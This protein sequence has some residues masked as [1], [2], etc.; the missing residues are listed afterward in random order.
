MPDTRSKPVAAA[1]CAPVEGMTAPADL[2][3][4]LLVEDEDFDARRL[5]ATLRVALGRAIDVRRVCSVQEVSGAIAQSMPDI[6]FIDDYLGPS[7]SALQTIPELR[8]AGY[9]GS[10]IVM[11][12]EMNRSRMTELGALGVKDALHK[13]DITSATITAAIDRAIA[14]Q[15][16]PTG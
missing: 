6:V 9:A 12:G 2:R 14:A 13:D 15:T 11:S 5:A 7:D 1:P 4:I 10:I 8:L 16:M 3:N